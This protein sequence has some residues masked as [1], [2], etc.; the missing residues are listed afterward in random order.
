[1]QLL[2]A[3]VLSSLQSLN[4][5]LFEHRV[6]ILDSQLEIPFHYYKQY[7]RNGWL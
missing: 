5:F 7:L 4:M 6:Y 2:H 1:M 3:P